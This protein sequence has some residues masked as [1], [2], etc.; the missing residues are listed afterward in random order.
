MAN[1]VREKGNLW[2]TEEDENGQIALPRLS[3]GVAPSF[4]TKVTSVFG[5]SGFPSQ[6]QLRTFQTATT[7]EVGKKS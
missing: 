6:S 3:T 1:L 2:M 7:A 5:P 4:S